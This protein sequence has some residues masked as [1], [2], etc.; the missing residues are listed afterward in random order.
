[1]SDDSIKDKKQ[2]EEGSA[3]KEEFVSRK[4]YQEV[5]QDMHKYKKQLK[6]VEAKLNEYQAKIETTEK[7]KLEEQER[8]K[9]LYQKEK[10][11]R[12]SIEQSY[13][14]D[15]ENFLS[16]HKKQAVKDAL[17]GFKRPEYSSFIDASKVEFNEDGTLDKQSVEA[18]VQRIKENYPEIIK[19]EQKRELPNN[20][21][22][23][24]SN[25]EKPLTG[26]DRLA[27]ALGHK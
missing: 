19:Q 27:R 2:N 8:W 17:G 10:E 20:E 14:K 21:A 22:P 25:N 12:T 16:V 26:K 9:E 24:P 1:M 5:S 7:E 11:A 15:R 18:E 3:E 23:K 6:E 13:Q 4:A